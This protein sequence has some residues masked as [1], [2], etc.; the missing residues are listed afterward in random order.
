[1]NI[2]GAQFVAINMIL[3]EI[4]FLQLTEEDMIFFTLGTSQIKFAKSYVNVHMRGEVYLIESS[5][6]HIPSIN[7]Y[8]VR[9]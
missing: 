6:E 3:N 2:R 7:N 9:T 1:M 4:G 8:G 5:E